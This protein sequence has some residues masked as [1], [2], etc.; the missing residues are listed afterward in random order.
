MSAR[1]VA[2]AGLAAAAL[3]AAPFGVELGEDWNLD[4]LRRL[5]D[6]HPP[7]AVERWLYNPRERTAR[8]LALLEAGDPVAALGALETA[9]RIA[10]DDPRVLF[11]LGTGRLLADHGDAVGALEGALRLEEGP[12]SAAAGDGLPPELRQRAF[13]NLGGARL[14]AGDPAGAVAAYEEALRLEPSD[15]DA[16]HNLEI[17][18]RRLEESRLRLRSPQEAPGGK[19]PGEEAPSDETGGTDP[20][21]EPEEDGSG[22]RDPGA[23]GPEADTRP[24]EGTTYG[25]R[26]LAG[27]DEQ[28]DL[29]AIQAAALL[30]AVEHLERRQRRQA[31]LRAAKRAGAAEED[32]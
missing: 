18:L 13:Y 1:A 22:G 19:R 26:P 8:G 29:S 23:E 32:W 24:P 7:A 31:A 2:L 28:A 27:F 17:A 25:R 10:P 12:E 3:L 6:V 14:A 11:N 9:G 20:E 5:L 4:D 21:T 15:A 16:K 30:E